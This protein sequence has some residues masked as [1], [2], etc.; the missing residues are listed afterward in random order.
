MYCNSDLRG[1]DFLGGLVYF[2]EDLDEACAS[3]NV[4]QTNN[5]TQTA[6]ANCFGVAFAV[7]FHETP[8]DLGR[9]CF[10]KDASNITATHR[11]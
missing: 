6:N 8:Q 7:D 3:F 2:L 11:G 9:K 5:G 10:L 4:Y 1:V